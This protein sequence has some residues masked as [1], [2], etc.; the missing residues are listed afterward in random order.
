VK[1]IDAEAVARGVQHSLEDKLRD[2]TK[3]A[4]FATHP[5]ATTD[6]ITSSQVSSR[7]AIHVP[8]LLTQTTVPNEAR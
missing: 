4:V 1:K 3:C 2:M 5:F 8:G 7:S 6:A